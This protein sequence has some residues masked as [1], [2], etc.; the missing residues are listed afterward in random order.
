MRARKSIYNVIFGIISQIII[1]ALGIIVPRVTL[2]N[3]GSDVNGYTS[4]VRQIFTYMALLEAGIGQ[5]TL[6]SLYE[7]VARS[8]R[9][10]ISSL[11]TASLKYYRKITKG[12]FGLVLVMS[13]ALPFALNT[14]INPLT[15]G[16]VVFFEGLS[17]VIGFYYL[18]AWKQLLSADGRYYV[19]QN[20]SMMGTVLV[21]GMKI[22]LSCMGVN[23]AVIQAGNFVVS[24]V[25]MVAYK[26]YCRKKYY[27]IDFS[28]EPDNSA[29]KD[30][31]SFMASQAA[32]TVFSSTDMIVLSVFSGT[33][34]ASVYSVYNLIYSNL[35]NLL[36]AIYFGLIFI[37]GQTW[38]A[39][40]E[41]Y[42]RLH[43]AFDGMSMWMITATMSVAYILTM[44]FVTIYTSG[45]EDVNYIYSSLPFLFAL[46]QLLSWSRYVSGNLVTLAGYAKQVSKIS[47]LEAAIN[48][49]LSIVLV[50]RFG[51]VGALFATVIALPVKVIY[52]L[53]VGN[54][55]VMQR[56]LVNSLKILIVN[57]ILFGLAVLFQAKMDLGIQGIADFLKAGV[58]ISAVIYP[59]YFI[60]NIVTNAAMRMYVVQICKKFIGRMGGKKI[61]QKL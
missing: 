55:K 28:A 58:M 7:P 61:E 10:K 47:L 57:Y 46:V 44:P 25:Q 41:K 56:S 22:V 52:C 1:I 2:T 20:L 29:L 54:R 33:L 59:L 42:P 16:F 8:D 17:A 19:T 31:Y 26:I 50:G 23:I 30:R 40:K 53:Y 14:D 3:Y 36:N 11:L 6:N 35:N 12:Y 45:I 49:I 21:Y 5:S 9:G 34:M 4:T 24:L 43:D 51:I 32:A 37:L 39:D 48:L 18:E 60:V 15:A 38:K 13:F 27:W